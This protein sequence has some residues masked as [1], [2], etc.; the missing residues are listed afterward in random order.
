MTKSEQGECL[1]QLIERRKELEREIALLSARAKTH[2]RAIL[3][4]AEYL[5]PV[6]KYSDPQMGEIHPAIS[7][8]EYPTLDR[9]NSLISEIADKK[10]E[11]FNILEQLKRIV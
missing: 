4:V 1:I 8:K 10:N 5:Q 2:H 9:V 7:N 11:L 6:T 3:L